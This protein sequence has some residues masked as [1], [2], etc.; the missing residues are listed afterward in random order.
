MRSFAREPLGRKGGRK[1]G[2][3]KRTI[4]LRYFW[5]IKIQFQAAT[6]CIS[7]FMSSSRRRR[8]K[9]SLRRANTQL[10][11]TVPRG[12]CKRWPLQQQEV[13]RRRQTPCCQRKIIKQEK[14]QCQRRS[15]TRMSFFLR[16][17]LLFSSP[18]SSSL[19]PSSSFNS[20]MGYYN[21]VVRVEPLGETRNFFGLNLCLQVMSHLSHIAGVVSPVPCCRYPAPTKGSTRRKQAVV[22]ARQFT[23]WA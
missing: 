9:S 12:T 13:R 19:S 11:A 5:T 4:S 15:R 23:S 16:F 22:T 14:V 10:R 18:P 21:R 6:L 17:L 7:P 1:E 20:L 2:A 3:S 8:A